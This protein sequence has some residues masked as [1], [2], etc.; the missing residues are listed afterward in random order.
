MIGEEAELTSLYFPPRPSSSFKSAARLS[1]ALSSS[2]REDQSSLPVQTRTCWLYCAINPLSFADRSISRPSGIC[3]VA[4]QE[5][6]AGGQVGI[7]GKG[8]VLVATLRPSMR[9]V[10]LKRTR[11]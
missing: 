6:V 3:V 10:S 11:A 9:G 2:M 5:H 8:G 1:P 4:A 7:T